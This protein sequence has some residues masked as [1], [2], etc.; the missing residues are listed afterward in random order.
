MKD[1]TCHPVAE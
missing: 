1:W